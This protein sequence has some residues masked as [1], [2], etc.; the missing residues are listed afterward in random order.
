MYDYP[1]NWTRIALLLALIGFLIL[2]Y[3]RQASQLTRPLGCFGLSILVLAVLSFPNFGFFHRPHFGAVH[4]WDAF[5]YFMG[6]KYFAELGYEGLYEATLVSGLEHKVFGDI[7]HIRSLRT[8]EPEDAQTIDRSIVKSRFS[9]ERWRAFATD[10]SYFVREI[11]PWEK[12]FFDHGYN[13][14]PMRAAL[15]GLITNRLTATPTTIFILSLIDYLLIALIALAIFRAFGSFAA[16]VT[17]SFLL[18][19]FLA[20]FNFIGGSIL[21]WDW[22][23]AILAAAVSIQRGKMRLAGLS[24]AYATGARIFPILFFAPLVLK[25]VAASRNSPDQ[26]ALRKLFGGAALGGLALTV[27]TLACGIGF[28]TVTTFLTKIQAH[29]QNIFLNHIGV[30]QLVAFSRTPWL[31]HPDIGLYIPREAALAARAPRWLTALIAIAVGAAL[32]RPLRS[33]SVLQALSYG[34]IFIFILL[35]PA[36][37]Y[38]SFLSL[39]ILGAVSRE[40]LTKLATVKLVL[41][42]VVTILSYLIEQQITEMLPLYYFVGVMLAV[43]FVGLVL[44]ERGSHRSS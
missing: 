21:R 6:S 33:C 11:G 24:L 26:V 19:N 5:H 3:R 43:Y 38:Y 41:L 40:P 16:I 37:Y 25:Y 13:D 12:L 31:Y 39:L 42:L 22:I 17:V 14:P 36:N 10:L 30:D 4:S 15:L 35:T 20:R 23:V 18:L 9:E 32:I 29:S 27:F 44:I 7:T 8:Y 34:G 2:V 1:I 28:D